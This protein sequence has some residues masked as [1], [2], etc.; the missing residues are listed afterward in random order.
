MSRFIY[1]DSKNLTESNPNALMS[2]EIRKIIH[3]PLLTR[4]TGTVFATWLP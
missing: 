1:L 2:E 4:S 3:L